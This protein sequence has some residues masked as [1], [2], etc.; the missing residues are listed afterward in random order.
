MV[1]VLDGSYPPHIV[2]AAKIL[3]QGNLLAFATE[4]VYGLG[5]DAENTN[6]V[7]QIFKTKRRPASHPLIVH[8]ADKDQ[9]SHYAEKVSAYA[10]RLMQAFWPGPL[11]LVLPR[12]KGIATLAAASQNS[13]GIRCPIHPVA[14]N[15]LK[16][17]LTLGV[18]G[19][20]A[21]SANH[22]GRISPTSA[23]HVV[24]EFSHHEDKLLVLDGGYCSL[25]IE[26]SIVS[27]LEEQPIL[28]RPGVIGRQQIEAVCKLKLGI[29]GQ[30]TPQV[31]GSLASHYAPHAK[32]L[33]LPRQE[34]STIPPSDTVALYHLPLDA[35]QAAYELF[36]QLRRLDRR[37]V[38]KIYVS[39][40]PDTPEWE[41]VRDRLKRA[42]HY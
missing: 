39:E 19:V 11:T 4:T 7:H 29:T 20:A 23:Q 27:C 14:Q 15:L 37:G 22:F 9:V 13:I 3:S 35:K 28:L 24:E 21:P 25:G 6:G 5:A 16:Q 18:T 42:S 34:I 32:L 38:E 8:I 41:G 31:S 12:Q 30:K 2:K 33:I 1:E 36:A 26:S 17:A 40:P 10:Y